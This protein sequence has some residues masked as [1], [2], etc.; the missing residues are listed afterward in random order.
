MLTPGHDKT[1]GGWMPNI[2]STSHTKRRLMQKNNHNSMSFLVTLFSEG[3]GYTCYN[4]SEPR[5]HLD[6]YTY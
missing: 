4:K 6:L 1:K 5:S 2:A 3:A